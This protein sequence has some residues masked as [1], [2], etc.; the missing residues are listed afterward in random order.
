MKTWNLGNTTVRNPERI[1]AGLALLKQHFEGKV[2]DLAAQA[3]FFDVLLEAGIIEGN[4]G[5]VESRAASGRK[6]QSV[7]NKLGLSTRSSRI[8]GIISITEAGD[9]LLSD[10]SLESDVFLRQLLKVQLPSPT[11]EKLDNAAVHPFFLVL[12]VAVELVRREM[13]PLGKEEIALFL[14]SATNDNQ[15]NEIVDAIAM[16]RA[17]RS[18]VKGSVAKSKFFRDSLLIKGRNIYGDEVSDTKLNTLKD[19]SDTTV[20][21]SVITGVFTI[22]RQSLIIK[23]D[24]LNLASAIVGAG[25]P[26]LYSE[27]EFLQYFHSPLLPVLPTDDV[28]FLRADIEA[29]N[30]RLGELSRQTGSQVAD[31]GEMEVANINKL[32][33]RRED[34]EAELTSLKEIQFYRAQ[35]DKEQVEDIKGLFESIENRETIGG[36]DYLPAWAEWNVW[37]VFLSINTLSNPISETRGFKINSELF[38]IHHAKGGQADLQFEYADGTIIP[39][40]ITLSTNERQYNMEGEPVQFHVKSIIEKNQS[41][42]VIGLFTA[43]NVHV[44]TAHVFYRADFYSQKLGKAVDMNIVPLTFTQL[45][46]LLPGQKNG[47][48]SGDELLNKLR[49]LISLKKTSSD[50]AVWLRQINNMLNVG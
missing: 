4:P 49:A 43:P 21:Y 44:S 16:Y 36:S 47:C 48:E 34:L 18:E 15:T 27:Q 12:S 46:S 26:P 11:E 3:K 8:N 19:Y 6:W 30:V 25:V 9:A 22:G 31:R 7:C 28:A 35:H 20:R 41:N 2:F 10:E 13:K 33:R 38:P 24:Q 42:E 14:Q 39:A 50:G 45:Q 37:R 32:K 40:E 23:E 1:K 29:L 5:L 17:A